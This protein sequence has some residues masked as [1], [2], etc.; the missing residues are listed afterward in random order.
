VA[1]PLRRHIK[2]HTR[3]PQANLTLYFRSSSSLIA[4]EYPK[5]WCVV[6]EAGAGF[7]ESAV[8]PNCANKVQRAKRAA[9]Y[10]RSLN[11]VRADAAFAFQSPRSDASLFCLAL[12]V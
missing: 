7:L 5:N 2:W 10:A 4:T 12:C 6:P 9:T 11:S 3:K 1:Q 8:A